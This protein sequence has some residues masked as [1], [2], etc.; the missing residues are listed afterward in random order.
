MVVEF[1]GP[2]AKY[3]Y[4][5][6]ESKEITLLV[7]GTGITPHYQLLTQILNDQLDTTI[8]NMIY[9]SRNEDEVLLME[10]LDQLATKYP[11]RFKITYIL[12]NPKSPSTWTGATGYI[13]ADMIRK[14]HGDAG[15]GDK[16]VFVCGPPAMMMAICGKKGP[17]GAQGDLDGS[18]LATLG[19]ESKEVW[20][21]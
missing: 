7:G 12:D 2:Y 15:S 13:T 4:Q 17:K 16:R 19:F 5:R 9:G 11:N 8:I 20:K 21:F 18:I 3:N 1:K 6:N 14:V 10:E